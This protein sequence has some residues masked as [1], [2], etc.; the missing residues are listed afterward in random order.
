M[1]PTQDAHVGEKLSGVMN[2]ATAAVTDPA[3]L[4]N[5]QKG[6]SSFWSKAAT[7]G[8]FA[9]L[10]VSL[11][12][13]LTAQRSWCYQRQFS[14]TLLLPVIFAGVGLWSS[15]ASAAKSIATDLGVPPAGTSAGAASSGG[16]FAAFR[17]EDESAGVRD[18]RGAGVSSRAPRSAQVGQDTG[19]RSPSPTP[20]S[21]A[22][23][24]EART[25]D[26]DWLAQQV[27]AVQLRPA[28]AT[29]HGGA[30]AR[31]TAV[32]GGEATARADDGDATAWD[33]DAWDTAD[34]VAVVASPVAPRAAARASP[35]ASAAA[36]T[37]GGN[38]DA[39]AGGR[40]PTITGASPQ[41]PAA[42]PPP[43]DDDDFFKS[44]GVA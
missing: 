10:S 11:L 4:D 24:T 43:A 18:G 13:S 19:R 15:A 42:A 28:G 17:D 22:T 16:G 3:L 40:M 29:N 41:P 23:A 14:A 2:A 37:A 34:A 20:P 12:A 1:L 32:K 25:D 33:T 9:A 38:I 21:V 27:A 26:D 31:R 39:Q 6:A 7:V 44:F 5:V 30:A 36:D 35:A 8:A